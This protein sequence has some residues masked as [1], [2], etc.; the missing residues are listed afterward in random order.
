MIKKTE[1][2]KNHQQVEGFCF[3]RWVLHVKEDNTLSRKIAINH[4]ISRYSVSRQETAI[5]RACRH[6]SLRFLNSREAEGK[7]GADSAK[8]NRSNDA[9]PNSVGPAYSLGLRHGGLL[10]SRRWTE[11]NLWS[12][13]LVAVGAGAF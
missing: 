2:R 9:V 13:R 3:F 12:A 6:I 10:P 4:N 1:S 7:G 5:Y 11:G 8:D